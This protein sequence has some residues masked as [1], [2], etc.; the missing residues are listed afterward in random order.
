M[1]LYDQ[2]LAIYERFIGIF[3]INIQWIISLIIFIF[4]VLATIDLI[5]RN[6]VFL[7]FLILLIP[8]SI[9]LLKSIFQGLI[10]FLQNLL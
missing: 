3:P 2:I 1:S 8:A 5:K 7:L 4:I 6:F 9:P 10:A